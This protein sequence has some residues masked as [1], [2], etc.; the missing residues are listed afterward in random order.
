MLPY[1]AD[2]A[3]YIGRRL[4]KS[5]LLGAYKHFQIRSL[6]LAVE[7]DDVIDL[8]L[9]RIASGSVSASEETRLMVSEKVEAAFAAGS[10]LADGG[11]TSDVSTSIASRSRLISPAS[12]KSTAA[13]SEKRQSR[14]RNLTIRGGPVRSSRCAGR[15]AASRSDH[16]DTHPASKS[17]ASKARESTA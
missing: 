8:R 16:K 12:L 14:C 5:S 15:A 9:R 13:S 3:G 2:R 10:I 6:V 7:C 4:N 17:P 1:G 11:R